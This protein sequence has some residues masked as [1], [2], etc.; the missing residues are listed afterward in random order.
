MLGTQVGTLKSGYVKSGV[1][2]N[3]YVVIF[4][5]TKGGRGL[6]DKPIAVKAI[7]SEDSSEVACYSNE[8]EDRTRKPEE[9]DKVTHALAENQERRYTCNHA[10]SCI[11]IQ[12]DI[13]ANGKTFNAN[14][15]Y[16]LVIK[17]Q[18]IKETIDLFR[19]N[20]IF[21]TDF[22]FLVNKNGYDYSI[23]AADDVHIQK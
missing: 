1:L 15:N 7:Y 6:L 4:R 8:A 16:V 17:S 11:R 14:E 10:A 12:C 23:N 5:F 13:G 21:V 20:S 19:N 18:I 9:D 3:F 22:R 2:K